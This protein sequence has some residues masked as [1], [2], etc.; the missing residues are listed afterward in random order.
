MNPQLLSYAAPPL[1]GAFI[2]YLTNK[3]AI[4]ML[5]RPLEP[6]HVLGLRVPMTPGVIPAKRHEL[7]KNI[8]VMVGEHLLTATDIGTALSREPFQEHLRELVDS[9]MRIILDKE[10]E[11][12]LS[13][14]PK[15]FRSYARVGMRTLKYQ[16]KQGLGDYLCSDTFSQT[17]A[18]A[19][20]E[21][22]STLG[23]REINSLFAPEE[24]ERLYGFFDELLVRILHS[25]RLE[26]RLTAYIQT[27]VMEAARSGKTLRDIL[28]HPF[29]ELLFSLLRDQ[30]PGLLARVAVL[31]GEPAMRDRI[32][33]AVRQGVDHFLSSLGP[34]AAMA[35]G[36]LDMDN[37]ETMT[38]EYLTDHEDELAAW[39]QSEEVRAEV[40]RVI[41]E[42]IHKMLSTPLANLLAKLSSR[43]LDELYSTVSRQILGTLQSPA[44]IDM[45]TFV[46][47]QGFEDILDRGK[48]PVAEVLYRLFPGQERDAL[49]RKF[50]DEFLGL[51]RTPGSSRILGRLVDRMM[52]MV[53]ARPIGV[54]ARLMPPGVREGIVDY[55]VLLINRILLAEVPGLVRSLQISRLV[56]AKVDSLDLLKLEGLLLSIMEEQ[57]KYINLFGG[58]LGFLIG[59]ANLLILRL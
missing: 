16:L 26:S 19:L 8:G 44:A 39:L 50:L 47:R 53:A 32:I 15:R 20:D 45:L 10:L 34:M 21:Q 49:R 9:R 23:D 51:L 52:D 38:R 22:F 12:L 11:G 28:P 4:K 1:I 37:L 58:L 30:V 46:I 29:V 59:L 55:L 35:K 57:F 42:Q 41:E 17:L 24:R 14:V 6:W 33:V 43:Q 2:G 56:T 54:L 25:D 3:I 13:L 48:K 40:G 31:L 27:R 7:A 36:F 18:E 5:F